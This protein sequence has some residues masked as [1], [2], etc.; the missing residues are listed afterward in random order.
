MQSIHRGLWCGP[1]IALM[2]V[3]LAAPA[4]AQPTLELSWMSIDCGGG[5]STGGSLQL[6]MTIGQSD[7]E[8]VSGGMFTLAAGFWPAAAGVSCYA[9]C[10]G[11]TAPPVLN[12]NDFSCFLNRYAAGDA[13]ANCDGSTASPVLNVND[14]SC[15]L[16]SYAAGCP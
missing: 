8:R 13:Y 6:S 3:G 16:N 14:F 7:A 15:F 4:W 2:V 9:N 1:R 12:V 11:S 10:D 5:V